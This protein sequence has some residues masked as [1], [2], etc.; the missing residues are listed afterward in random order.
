[1][2]GGTL[3]VKTRG[4]SLQTSEVDEKKEAFVKDAGARYGH[5][6]Q[7]IWR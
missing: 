5:K 7:I 3:I 1:M 2:K 6:Y 4:S